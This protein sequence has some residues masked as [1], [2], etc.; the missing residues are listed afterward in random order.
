MDE[1]EKIFLCMHA[2]DSD[3]LEFVEYLLKDVAY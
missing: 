3:G 2:T 1:I